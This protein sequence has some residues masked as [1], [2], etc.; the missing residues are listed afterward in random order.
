MALRTTF[1]WSR[2][3][4][5]DKLDT[6]WNKE[7]RSAREIAN[8]LGIS[9]GAVLGKVHRMGWSGEGAGGRGGK[10]GHRSV[11]RGR[12]HKTTTYKKKQKLLFESFKSAADHAAREELGLSDLRSPPSKV[13]DIKVVRTDPPVEKR[14]SLFDLRASSCRWP[15]PGA[16]G[17]QLY[18]GCKKDD[19]LHPYCP[20]HMKRAY[21]PRSGRKLAVHNQINFRD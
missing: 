15:L 5:T 20:D 14:I 11:M 1:N 9:R 10:N 16:N 6:W 19:V 4:W 17:E 18:C 2:M 12:G 3:G 21:K 8:M 13:M 7:G